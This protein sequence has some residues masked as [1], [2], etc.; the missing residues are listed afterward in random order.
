MSTALLLWSC[1]VQGAATEWCWCTG[2]CSG[3]AACCRSCACAAAP[4][5]AAWHG[6]AQVWV[7][8]RSPRP[9]VLLPPLLAL[10]RRSLGGAPNVVAINVSTL[11][12][13]LSSE[14]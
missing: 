12:A 4:A 2:A 3:L 5:L 10:P 9:A 13:E 6:M 14:L 8:C 11:G 1:A 7:H